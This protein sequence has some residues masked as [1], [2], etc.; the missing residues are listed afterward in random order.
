MHM[1]A[2]SKRIR[3][4][5]HACAHVHMFAP[6]HATYAHVTLVHTQATLTKRKQLTKT[7]RKKVF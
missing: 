6:T 2:S 1:R 5:M 4:C 7:K 3:A